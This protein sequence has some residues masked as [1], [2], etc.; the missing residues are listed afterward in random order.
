MTQKKTGDAKFSTKTTPT[1]EPAL[2]ELF[3]DCIKD[4]YWAENHL[5]KSLPKM[6]QAATSADLI[7]AI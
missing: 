5:V 4:I 6:Q 2:M 1:A 7:D 3:V